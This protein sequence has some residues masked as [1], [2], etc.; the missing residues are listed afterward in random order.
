MLETRKSTDI[1]GM[2]TID[3]HTQKKAAAAKERLEFIKVAKF[4]VGGQAQI[5][6]RVVWISDLEAADGRL[7]AR[8]GLLPPAALSMV[9]TAE[10]PRERFVASLH[11]GGLSGRG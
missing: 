10:R 9:L 1:A 6:G 5:D 2:G 8:Q 11:A 3:E 7:G 4:R